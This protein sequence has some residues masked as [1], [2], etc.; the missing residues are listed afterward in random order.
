MNLD[1]WWDAMFKQALLWMALISVCWNGVLAGTN[2]PGV[3]PY[4]LFALGK[5]DSVVQLLE[6]ER[7]ADT[8]LFPTEKQMLLGLAYARTG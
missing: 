7:R 3:D 4:R 5:V 2:Q 1:S 8:A 6:R